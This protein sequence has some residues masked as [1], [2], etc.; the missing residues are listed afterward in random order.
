[1]EFNDKIKQFSER[2][3]KIKDTALTE[4]STK[5]SLIV[6]LFQILGYDVFNPLEF[7]PEYTADVGIKKGEKVDYAILQ[8]GNPT[9]LIECKSCTEPLDKHSSQLF[10][11]FST[12]TAKFGIL[13]NGIVYKFYTDLEEAN[14]MDLTPFLEIDMRNIKETYIN[15]LKKF[16]KDSFDCDKIF[17]TAEELKFSSLIKNVLASEYENPSETFVKF[18]LNKIYDGQ[19]NQKVIEKFTPV[20][21]RAFSS[22]VN[23][24]V[25][26]KISAALTSEPNA[27]KVN[28]EPQIEEIVDEPASKIVTTEDEIEAFYIIR[29]ILAGILPV[30]D[31]TYKDT[32]SYFGILYKENIKKTIC[33][34]N[35][36]KK[37]KQLFIPM[38]DKKYEKIYIQ[39]SN[40]L[41]LY[42]DKLIDVV[43]RYTGNQQN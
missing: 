34:V 40:D 19:K 10:R 6:P 33:R 18:M 42:R 26:D 29:G 7:C 4:E 32:E 39:S 27:E 16:C 14:K 24:M 2:V 31:V 15:Q 3:V 9:I 25:N 13:T 11:Y 35:L 28:V 43:S 5:M 37:N 22:F 12:T 36:D 8:G 38:E 1:M 23:E 20:I 30:E 17:S 41:Y 21:K